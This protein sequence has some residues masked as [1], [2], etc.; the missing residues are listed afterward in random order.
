MSV[1]VYLPGP[2]RPLADGRDRFE[3]DAAGTVAGV[4][5]GI[6]RDLP[7]VHHRIVTEQGEVRPHINIFVGVED[8]RRTGGLGTPVGDAAE[9]HIL[10]AVSGG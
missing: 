3:L 2:L 4:L 9:I 6:R 10:P 8:I 5:D 1:T 7:A